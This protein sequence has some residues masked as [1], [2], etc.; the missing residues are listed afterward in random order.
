MSVVTEDA[1]SWRRALLA[2]GHSRYA[3]LRHNAGEAIVSIGEGMLARHW[4]VCSAVLAMPRDEGAE[5]RAN[6]W[7]M[8]VGQLLRA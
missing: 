6:V 3:T 5:R 4:S 7:L 2:A 8:P 1:V